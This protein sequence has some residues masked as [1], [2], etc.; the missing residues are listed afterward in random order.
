LQRFPIRALARRGEHVALAD[1]DRR[2]SAI[3]WLAAEGLGVFD[4]EPSPLQPIRR[5]WQPVVDFLTA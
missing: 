4:R 1:A 2:R 3:G 5:Q